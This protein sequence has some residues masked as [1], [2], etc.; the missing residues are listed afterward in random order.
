[1]LRLQHL[2]RKPLKYSLNRYLNRNFSNDLQVPTHA[3]VVIIGGGIIGNSVAYH[4]GMLALIHQ[5]MLTNDSFT[6]FY[7]Y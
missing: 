5:L 6:Y 7:L 4:L 1:M 2:Q 3:R